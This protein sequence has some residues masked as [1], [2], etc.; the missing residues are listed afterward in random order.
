MDPKWQAFFFALAV[1]FALVDSVEW[2]PIRTRVVPRW[3]AL[4]IACFAFPF[5]YGA[6]VAGW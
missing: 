4:A 5:F 3:T 1:L 6:V 2:R